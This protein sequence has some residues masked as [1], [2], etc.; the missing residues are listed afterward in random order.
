MS[1]SSPSIVI[2]GTGAFCP[3]KILSNDDLAKMVDTSDEWIRTR[4]G[5]QERRIAE[6]KTTSQMAVEAAKQALQN[7]KLS[8]QDIDLVIVSTITPDMPFPSTA[9]LVQAQLGIPAV[10]CFDLEAAC[11]GFLYALEVGTQML[12]SG[13]Y[14]N[15]LLIGAE[16][17]SSIIDWEDRNTCVLF[18]D[19]AGAVVLSK[20]EKADTGVLGT[21]LGADG[22][23][24]DLLCMPGS[25]SSCPPTQTSLEQRQHFLK[26]NGREIFKS[27]VRVMEQATCDILKQHQLSTSDVACIVPH[28]ANIRIFETLAER[29]ELPLDRF[30]MNLES[31]GNTSAASIPIALHE[32]WEQNR[33]KPGDLILLVAFGGGLTWGS[34]LIRW[35]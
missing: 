35:Q 22:S 12:R 23:K 29:L 25:G 33:L 34:S 15:A 8:A 21:L 10:A 16:K 6:D 28:Q 13:N 9:A 32:A 30:F 3:P 18:G 11:S 17:M 14:K 31:Y 1:A 26:M 19:G 2:Q 5:I 4:T 27:A 24:G 20:T 7:A